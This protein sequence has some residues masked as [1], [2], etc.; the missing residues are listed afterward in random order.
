[1]GHRNLL[2]LVVGHHRDPLAKRHRSIWSC[3]TYT[4]VVSRRARFCKRCV[5]R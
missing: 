4:V 5:G 1:M 2:K 3:V